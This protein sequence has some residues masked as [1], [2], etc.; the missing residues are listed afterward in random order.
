MRMPILFNF[1][2]KM[3]P[4]LAKSSRVCSQVLSFVFLM[5]SVI[6][7][8]N[9]I[10]AQDRETQ[11]DPTEAPLI[12]SEAQV[13]ES[14]Q[15]QERQPFG[16]GSLLFFPEESKRPEDERFEV[17]AGTWVPVCLKL[18][19]LKSPFLQETLSEAIGFELI[20][21]DSET[22][23]NQLKIQFGPTEKEI[24]KARK[25][26]K[27]PYEPDDS[28]CYRTQFT[29]PN[30]TDPGVYQVA[31]LLVKTR[32][33]DYVSLKQ[34]L[35]QFSKA[36]ELDIKNPDLDQKAPELL[37]ISSFKDQAQKL[38]KYGEFVRLKLAQTFIVSEEESGVKPQTLQVWYA[39]QEEGK[40]TSIYPAQCKRVVHTRWKFTCKL[41][42]TRPLWQWKD[43][44]L[45]LVL[46]TIRLED[47]A[48]NAIKI[49]DP[50]AFAQKAQEE[51][52]L[53]EY[54]GVRP[55]PEYSPPHQNRY[56]EL[57]GRWP[58]SPQKNK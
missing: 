23:P 35:L 24:K 49:Q 1:L 34:V 18:N 4:S 27:D 36:E 11:Y 25:A 22:P 58:D 53:F 37:E 50:K 48:G 6:I 43:A 16:G 13:S 30:Y 15:D 31:D 29:I 28:G 20:L 2:M 52:I 21:E 39:L 33:S 41:Q 56:Q 8:T 3:I 38:G 46:E 12:P 5:I 14:P 51:P 26:G 54:E 19:P 7:I 32:L 17:E 42:V 47:K 10:R 45:G 55:G 57:K 9:P 44:R 40:T